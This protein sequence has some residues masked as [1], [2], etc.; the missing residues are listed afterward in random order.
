MSERRRPYYL[1]TGLVLGLLLGMLYARVLNPPVLVN[2]TPG[3]LNPA[4]QDQY[5]LMI[6]LAYQ[7]DG[8]LGRASARLDLLGNNPLADLA[9]QAQRML[10]SGG[11]MD[12]ARVLALLAQA[13]AQPFAPLPTIEPSPTIT[14]SST[15]ELPTLTPSPTLDL[16]AV[17]HSPTPSRTPPQGASPTGA[18]TYTPRPSNTPQPTAGAPFL[19]QESR[20]VCDVPGAA[21]YLVVEVQD[22]A[23][24]P[25]AGVR[26]VVSWPGGQDEFY[27]GLHP[28]IDPGYADFNMTEGVIYSVRAGEGGQAAEEISTGGCGMGVNGG[29]SVLFQQP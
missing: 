3:R 19:P 26:I 21:G 6:A 4:D 29:W 10:A 20:A 8:D 2:L 22:A 23:G 1:I 28:Q 18:A 5:R 9:S 24:T 7:T 12:E 27:T 17:V 16:A 11:S 15:P 14:P 13:L 25:V